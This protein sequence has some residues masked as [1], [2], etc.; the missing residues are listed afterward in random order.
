[1]TAATLAPPDQP[2]AVVGGII[3]DIDLWFPDQ[4]D[5]I[6]PDARWHPD[7]RPIAFPDPLRY[8]VWVA[9]RPPSD[10]LAPRLALHVN[11]R[12]AA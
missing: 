8:V 9:P 11:W 2:L 1:M 10:E 12:A 6:G 7:Y 3:A 5:P 4:E